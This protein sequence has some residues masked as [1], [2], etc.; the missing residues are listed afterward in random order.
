MHSFLN[1]YNSLSKE[2]IKGLGPKKLAL[3]EKLKLFT[4][5]DL[6]FNFPH[7]YEFQDNIIKIK[8]L[9]ENEP[10]VCLGV[11]KTITTDD[12]IIKN[13]K[14]NITKVLISDETG[15]VWATFFN[16]KYIYNHFEKGENVVLIGTPAIDNYFKV[17]CFSGAEIHKGKT[18]TPRIIPIY[19]QVE[20]ISSEFIHKIILAELDRFL[21]Y[22]KEV[23]PFEIIKKYDLVDRVSALRYIHNPQTRDEIDI[24]HKRFKIE[25][26]FLYLSKIVKNRFESIESGVNERIDLSKHVLTQKYINSLPFK[27]T[28]GQLN[29]IKDVL[30]DLKTKPVCNRLIQGDVGSGKTVVAIALLLNIAENG[31]QGALVAPTETLAEQHYLGIEDA[32][33]SMGITPLLLTGSLSAKEKQKAFEMIKSGEAKIIIGTHA[34]FT[35]NVEF[36]KLGMAII[37]EQHKFGVEQRDALRSKG[38]FSHVINMSA[39]PIP[40]SVAMTVYGDMD[41]SIIDVMPEGRQPVITKWLPTKELFTKAVELTRKEIL[42]GR[43]AYIVCPSIEKNMESKVKLLAVDTVYEN[44]KKHPLLKEFSIEVLH[45]KTNLKEKEDIMKRFKAGDIKILISTTVIEVGVNV[46]NA[47]VMIIM[48]ADRFGLAQL[49]QLRGRVGRGEYKGYCFLQTIKDVSDDCNKRLSIMEKTRDGF[50]IAEEDL[51]I[52]KSGK[53]FGLEQS[54]KEDFVFNSLTDDLDLIV[55]VRDSVYDIFSKN[56]IKNEYFFKELELL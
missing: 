24:A 56:I 23:L 21:G 4:V 13:R 26:L 11:V 1:L 33:L 15:E 22:M 5:K 52:R 14:M 41:V 34:L 36:H 10:A 45:G 18:F 20:D 40:K 46:P 43:Q 47:S 49:H 53:I 25:E 48:D 31:Y 38:Y 28:A 44:I 2:K 16:Q 35:D 32:F 42:N 8:D 55:N 9:K 50:I 12:K 30:H 27:L 3:F 29:A 54:G 39:T 37:D 7:R 51:K 17:I 19:S 6:L